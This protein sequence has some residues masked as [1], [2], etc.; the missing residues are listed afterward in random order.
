MPAANGNYVSMAGDALQPD[1]PTRVV[2]VASKPCNYTGW[3]SEWEMWV[4]L[5][6]GRTYRTIFDPVDLTHG[7]LRAISAFPTEGN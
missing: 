1:P 5:W 2:L 3:A 6:G 4:V 7:R